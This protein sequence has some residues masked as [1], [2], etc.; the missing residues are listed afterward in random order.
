MARIFFWFIRSIRP[1][2]VIH[3]KNAC[4]F[5]KSS[6][7]RTDK[8]NP[9]LV[10][11]TRKESIMPSEMLKIGDPAPDFELMSDTGQTVKLSDFRG[12]RVIVYFY[13]KDDTPGCIAQACGF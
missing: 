1:I 8:I 12:K 9:R 5:R 13:P 4:E 3:D 2:C 6:R 11:S 10:S 7:I